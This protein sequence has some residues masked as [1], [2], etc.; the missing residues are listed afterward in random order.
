MAAGGLIGFLLLALVFVW[1][2]LQQ[3]TVMDQVEQKAAILASEALGT[4]VEVGEITVDSLQEVTIRDIVLYD[5]QAECIG[6]AESAQVHFRLLSMLQD[7]VSAVDEIRIR[8]AEAFLAQRE[9]GTWN[10]ED[11]Q[12]SAEGETSFRGTVKLEESRASVRLAQGSELTMEQ[13][14]G[15]AELSDYPEVHVDV[16]GT[17]NE[18]PVKVSGTLS[19][20]RQILHAESGDIN[21]KDYLQFLPEGILPEDIKIL[22]GR[23][24]HVNVDILNR[25]GVLSAYGQMAC[26]D[27]SVQVMETEIRNIR[28]NVTFTDAEAFLSMDAE[29]EQQEAHVQGRVRWDGEEPRLDLTASSESFA[30]GEI[31]QDIPVEGAAAF[32]AHITGTAQSPL[33]DGTIKS[34]E[35]V[36]LDIPLQDLSAHVRYG[37]DVVY[38]DQLK[39][40]SF[41]GRISG[42]AEL[43]A[44]ELAY[45]AH[46]K[47]DGI[48][49]GALADYLS[50][51]EEVSGRV[52]ADLGIHGQ[53]TEL[54]ALTVYGGVSAEQGR[55]QEVPVE[56]VDTSFFLQGDN[57]TVDYLSI[58]MPNHSSIGL[59]GTVRNGR[60]LDLAFYGGHVD[61]SLFSYLFPEAELSG[62]SD[63]RGTVK[64]DSANPM[65]KMDF[66]GLHGVL[67]NQPYDSLKT[68][69]SGSLDGIGIDTFQMEKD[70][71]DVW[72]VMGSIG[73]TGERKLDLRVDTEGARMEDIVSLIAPGQELT[74]N[75]DNTIRLT[76][77]MD[78]P[79]MVGYI[80]FTRGSYNGILISGM[81]GDYYV[82]GNQLR[83]QD[84]HIYSPMVDMDVNGT[85]DRI[86]TAMDMTVVV[87]DIN[88]KR[89]RHKLPYDTEGHGTFEGKIG[90]TLDNPLFNGVLDAPELVFNGVSMQ[91]VHGKVLYDNGRLALSDFGFYQGE[92]SYDVAA[93]LDTNT[94][95]LS[96][97]LIVQDVEINELFALANQKNKLL[98]GRLN[99]TIR[100]GG[101]LEN[102]SVYLEGSIP[103]GTFAGYDIHSIS[104]DASLVNRV[105]SIHKMSG[106]QG[107]QG[108]FD[109]KGTADLDGELS[110]SLDAQNLAFGMFSKAA[111]IETELS[112]TTGITVRVGGT[113]SNPSA[114][115]DLLAEHGGVGTSSFDTLR[116]SAHL[117]NGL[118]DIPLLIVQK[119]LGGQV[120][121]ASANGIVPLRAL[122]AERSEELDEYERIKLNLALDQADLSLLPMMSD[123]VEWAVGATKGNLEI[124]GT[125][126]Y[127]LIYGS[128]EVPNGGMKI[129]D[130][131]KPVENMRIAVRFSG[132][133]VQ[134]EDCYGEM[135]KGHYQFRGSMGFG[136]LKPTDYDFS[137]DVDHLDL[138][139]D[140]YRGPLTMSFRLAEGEIYGFRMPKLSGRMDFANCQISVPQLPESEGELPNFI[141]DV[142]IDVGKD[143]HFYSSVLY[144]MYLKGKIHFGGTTRHP[145]SSGSVRVER[146]GTV[147]YLKTVFNIR[148]G[149]AHFDQVASF[150]PSLN[151]YADTK[152]PQAR[153]GLALHGPL[154]QM[155]IDL[156]S[157]PEMSK[158]EIIQLLTFRDAY[159]NGQV[160]ITAGDML[161]VGLQIGLLSGVED[162]VRNSLYLDRFAI[163]RG[164]GSI[165]KKYDRESNKNEDIYNVQIGKYVTNK[166]MVKYTQSFGGDTIRRYGVQYELND[167]MGLTLEREGN[168][169][170]VGFEGTFKF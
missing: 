81:D 62:L 161:L 2:I 55:I 116:G 129:K 138:Q 91:A 24:P 168:E 124:T 157:D 50:V 34:A 170:I 46:V 90:G 100:L 89:I 63:F 102:P 117:K 103:R 107:E 71:K 74:G 41:G 31:L 47:A 64:G 80:H 97:L 158:T 53:G 20:E 110:V 85:L 67:F 143:V 83:L 126:A 156:H 5:R 151:F 73:L 13:I 133:K 57:L 98:E 59:E 94:E 165:F 22:G 121:Q 60:M 9:D 132:D 152:L 70:G 72:L 29:A 27:G 26:E 18:S 17:V 120:Y 159:Q 10:L 21:L 95:E 123:Y 145:K 16:D 68:S 86:T 87:H 166:V 19:S 54:S 106:L 36:V 76:G 52:S 51:P 38:V 141:L 23:L 115:V 11:I 127:P 109:L 84:F 3:E 44:R 88:M 160:H 164:D 14:N 32:E 125:L 167:R 139:S 142:G 7:P 113:L 144:D 169:Y 12:T 92:G 131:E 135:G 56:S 48:D 118:I 137:L 114:D 149:E 43:Q 4:E 130:V 140:F 82:E 6:K 35:A 45:T 128:V 33:V 163:S 134:V 61:L 30:P 69:V 101:N 40:G 93:S 105:I 58:Q 1:N 42:E 77:T 146:G 111:G 104:V 78:H 8:H 148:E 147:S 136:G 79:E 119:E 37:H 153:I 99:S 15:E 25:D 96:G 39:A 162:V 122:Q 66:S 65:V 28:G 155:E 112:G 150:L 108:V 75:V 154:N 49:A